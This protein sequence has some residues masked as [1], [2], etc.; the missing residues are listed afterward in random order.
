[1]K[2]ILIILTFLCAE[3]NLLAQDT[4][5][6]TYQGIIKSIKGNPDSL[7]VT[8]NWFGNQ[9]QQFVGKLLDLLQRPESPNPE[10]CAAAY[11]LG[12]LRAPEAASVLASKI[13]LQYT[14][15]VDHLTILMRSPA[16]E[17]LIKIGDP[18]I[19]AVIRNLAESDDVKVREL[20]L[21]V[22]TRI[23]ND[24]D[25]SKLRLQKTIK[26]EADP[27]KQARLQAALK[28]LTEMK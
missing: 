3:T 2:L 14:Y 12:E 7:D 11:Y 5:E 28:S 13:T 10:Q 20:S 16:F 15:P 23:D 25:I 8:I 6:I 19:S 24:K 26:A 1:M 4:N 27:Q 9:R 21:Q 17:A 18:S 22:L